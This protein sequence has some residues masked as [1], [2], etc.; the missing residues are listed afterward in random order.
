MK[1]WTSFKRLAA[2][3]SIVAA[4]AGGLAMLSPRTALSLST[5]MRVIID[6]GAT[7]NNPPL[8][9]IS[10][11]GYVTGATGG[12]GATGFH[13]LSATTDNATSLKATAGV[14]YS[15][16]WQNSTATAMMVRFYDVATAPTCASSAVKLNFQVPAN[17]TSAGGSPNL[18]AAGIK[19]TNGIGVCITAPASGF[20]D[21]D[22][23]A[24]V[25]GLNLNG[26]YQ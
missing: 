9:T 26:G 15:V 1:G 24:A 20:P 8:F 23:T 4:I 11:P 3:L 19:F 7:P 10:N 17:T 12:G 22:D 25:A 16:T 18:G 2:G 6:D 5:A 21:N 13:L 14:L